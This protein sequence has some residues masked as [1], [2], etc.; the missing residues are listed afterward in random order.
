MN[1]VFESGATFIWQN[2]RLL[3]RAIF[4]YKFLNAPSNRI[5]Q[6]LRTYLN[7]D[8]GFGHAL[9]P[10]LRCPESQPLFVEFAL[11]TL[12]DCNLRDPE[13]AAK[14]CEFVSRHADL[15]NGIPLVFPSFKQ[16][17]HP[18]HMD[19]PSASQPSMDRLS[20][21]V[22][23]LYWQG[24]RNPWLTQAVESC[25][26]FISSTRFTDAHTILT[27][28]CLVEAL[29]PERP[30]DQMLEKLKADLFGASFFNL[31]A[32]T[33][34]YGLSPLIFAPTPT[35]YLRK[36]FTDA[37]IGAHLDALE[38]Q[39]EKDGGWPIQWEPPA[40]T[41]RPEW[42]AYKTVVALSTLRAYGRI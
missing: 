7:D 6:I 22:G 34:T 10:D 9:E 11:R 23:L 37:Q 20:G 25:A 21:L 31:D 29:S 16:Y 40:G 35:S 36:L 33:M 12:Y 1:R 39:Q 4:A 38:Q 28:F 30:V 32:Q 42:R 8:G 19:G 2:A 18:T 17:P 26:A 41:S 27:A 24:I 13:L 3:E 5:L 14:A 15:K